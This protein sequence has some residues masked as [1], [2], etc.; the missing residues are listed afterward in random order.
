[1]FSFAMKCGDR[2]LLHWH[3]EESKPWILR[4]NGV[5]YE[6]D[7][8]A[9][10]G[11]SQEKIP[12]LPA[13]TQEELREAVNAE[14]G[15]KKPQMLA[16]TGTCAPSLWG[17]HFVVKHAGVVL[18]EIYEF[19]L[20]DTNKSYGPPFH[21]D[22]FAMYVVNRENWGAP[23][24]SV[25]RAWPEDASR[26]I[27]AIIGEPETLDSDGNEHF[28]DEELAI[29][30][31]KTN[32]GEILQRISI[33]SSSSV[34][35]AQGMNITGLSIDTANYALRPDSRAFGVRV[36]YLHSGEFGLGSQSLSLF[37]VESDH[38]KSLLT[39][40]PMSGV[41]GYRGCGVNTAVERILVVA[42]SNSLGYADLKLIEHQTFSVD[43]DGCK[44]KAPPSIKKT[45]LLRFDGQEYKSQTGA[46]ELF[47]V[48]GDSD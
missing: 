21:S 30:I 19:R 45:I 39:H 3:I 14:Q 5:R 20:P 22:T 34:F 8:V 29:F 16:N 12:K 4:P 2:Y 37:E 36:S 9:E 32:T 40:L 17:R 47:P 42:Q 6:F 7:S 15:V 44:R 23:Q 31:A 1:L 33:P 28:G 41:A 25:S 18:Q 26:T 13:Y 11:M 24:F 48:F 10:I 46:I 27:V 38:L 35:D 43:V